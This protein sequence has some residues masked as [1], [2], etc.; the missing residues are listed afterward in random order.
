VRL[1]LLLAA[2]ASGVAAWLWREDPFARD[3]D[4]FQ[5]GDY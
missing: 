4:Y 1:V 3:F 5:G 2:V